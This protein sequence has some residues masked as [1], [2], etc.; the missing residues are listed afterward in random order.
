[1][2]KVI[3][4]LFF[5]IFFSVS[6]GQDIV[7][8]RIIISKERKVPTYSQIKITGSG[9]VILTDGQVGH[10]IVE[11]SENIEP[12]VLTEVER[13]T[14]VV[15]LKSGHTYRSIKK[16]KVYVPV[17]QNF[18]KLTMSGSGD[19]DSSKELVLNDLTCHMSGS[20]DLD[21]SLRAKS[22]NI[23]MEGSGDIELKGNVDTLKADIVGSGDLEAKKLKANKATL[24]VSGSGDMDVFVSQELSAT[25]SGSGDVTI[26][27]NPQKRD[28]KIR[29]S[30]DVKFL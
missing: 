5:L 3:V 2:K 16:L 24:S 29:G 23:S 25:I 1:M 9:D 27:G 10:L 18:N 20:G 19:V 22:L 28:T 14:L 11:T 12:Y 8:S 13:G 15:R 30:G 17:D 26:S 21:L 6:C 7:G 4:F